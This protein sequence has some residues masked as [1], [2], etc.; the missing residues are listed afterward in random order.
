MLRESS[1]GT[2]ASVRPRPPPECRSP[3]CGPIP[4]GP[5]AD[6]K[7]QGRSGIPWAEKRPTA[8]YRPCVAFQTRPPITAAACNLLHCHD[9]MPCWRLTPCW[10]LSTNQHSAPTRA[11]PFGSPALFSIALHPAPVILA[12]A[13][14]IAL[15]SPRQQRSPAVIGRCKASLP[16]PHDKAP[17]SAVTLSPVTPALCQSV[18][19]AHRTR[20]RDTTEYR[21][22]GRSCFCPFAPS[23]SSAVSFA[24]NRSSNAMRRA[25]SFVFAVEFCRRRRTASGLVQVKAGVRACSATHDAPRGNFRA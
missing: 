1:N 8:R 14:A 19:L 9:F 24:A 20:T 11:G 10:P 7:T 18:P 4:L 25:A 16:I 23:A 22:E 21:Q 17:H 2:G 12:R 15:T 13:P 5:H 6:A 3:A